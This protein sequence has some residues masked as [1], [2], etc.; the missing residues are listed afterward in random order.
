MSEENNNEKAFNNTVQTLLDKGLQ[1]DAG[2]HIIEANTI[3]E[4]KYQLD[5][6]QSFHGPWLCILQA[7][8][9]TPPKQKEQKKK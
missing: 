9:Q 5:A 8:T 6:Y 2:V 3:S 4:V 7:Q 1:M